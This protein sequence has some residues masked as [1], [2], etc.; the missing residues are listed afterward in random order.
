MSAGRELGRTAECSLASLPRL[1]VPPGDNPVIA[2]AYLEYRMTAFT[3]LAKKRRTPNG[4][5]RAAIYLVPSSLRKDDEA[6]ARQLSAEKVSLST[7]A[8]HVQKTSG[9]GGDSKKGIFYRSVA[10]AIAASG[11]ASVAGDKKGAVPTPS[12]EQSCDSDGEKGVAAAIDGVAASSS[13]PTTPM[14]Y[15]ASSSVPASP[16]SSS[17]SS[18]LSG[19]GEDVE[20]YRPGVGEVVHPIALL[21]RERRMAAAAAAATAEDL[22]LLNH[23]LAVSQD[24]VTRVLSR[25]LTVFDLTMRAPFNLLHHYLVSGNSLF[26]TMYLGREGHTSVN[27]SDWEPCSYD[28]AAQNLKVSSSSSSGANSPTKKFRRNKNR[29]SSRNKSPVSDAE[30]SSGPN[31][32]YST[33]LDYAASDNDGY[34][35]AD[36]SDWD[37][38][39]RAG[40]ETSEDETS[41]G[42][43]GSAASN[44][45]AIPLSDKEAKMTHPASLKSSMSGEV[46]EQGSYARRLTWN[47]GVDGSVRTEIQ[48]VRLN[49]DNCTGVDLYRSGSGMYT[50]NVW[51]RL[52]LEGNKPGVTHICLTCARGT[53]RTALRAIRAEGQNMHELL[54]TIVA[55]AGVQQIIDH[56]PQRRQNAT[57]EAP[58]KKVKAIV[59]VG[60]GGA[61]L[62][63]LLVA[64]MV[65]LLWVYLYY[66]GGG[67]GAEEL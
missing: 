10:A 24:L 14:A 61:A 29:L 59:T 50:K 43:T 62:L 38:A 67:S 30:D 48:V 7:H 33:D 3:S 65:F 32:Y 22:N 31:P 6:I 34:S 46:R 36:D 28:F 15:S 63:S 45:N 60:R 23:N 21:M 20:V 41:A 18:S 26:M 39:G 25:D 35:N 8:P 47:D 56:A 49:V 27:V 64:V 19:G 13:T 53:P 40:G 9:G 52:A 17:F 5:I 66:I 12:L 57:E 11:I 55:Q 42:A 51:M 44:S 37:N 54:Q 58:S 2:P 4:S 1:I 16:S